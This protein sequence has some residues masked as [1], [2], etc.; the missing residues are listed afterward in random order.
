MK[1]IGFFLVLIFALQLLTGCSVKP[2]VIAKKVGAA[3]GDGNPKITKVLET[4]TD[5]D[6]SPMYRISLKG[7]FHKENLTA[8]DLNF[9]DLTN[10]KYVWSI[11]ATDDKQNQVWRD[12]QLE[13]R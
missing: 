4:K 9:S 1:F 2:D 13:S 8:T 6:H 5:N 11:T 3:Y 7:S 10:G 12:D